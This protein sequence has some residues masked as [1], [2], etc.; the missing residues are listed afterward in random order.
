MLWRRDVSL[1]RRAL[2]R[3]NEDC[4]VLRELAIEDRMPFIAYLLGLVTEE[5]AS[6][7]EKTKAQAPRS[8]TTK[9]LQ[10]ELQPT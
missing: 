10:R 8:Q 2:Q 9:A 5:T 6:E 7:L 3:I 1:N 4:L